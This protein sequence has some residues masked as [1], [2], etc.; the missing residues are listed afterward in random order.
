MTGSLTTQVRAGGRTLGDAPLVSLWESSS[1]DRFARWD[2]GRQGIARPSVVLGREKT[3]ASPRREIGRK[4]PESS[5]PFSPPV[6][7]ETVIALPRNAVSVGDRMSN[8]CAGVVD[9][10]QTRRRPETPIAVRR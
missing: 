8:H 1:H 6:F 3:R 2:S 10:G 5:V 4:D 9:I 7:V